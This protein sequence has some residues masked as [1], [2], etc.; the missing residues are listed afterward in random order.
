MSKASACFIGGD[1]G[2]SRLRLFL[3]DAAGERLATVDGPGAA[4]ARHDYEALFDRLVSPWTEQHG[5]LPAILCGM[6]GSS[7]GWEQVPYQRCPARPEDIADACLA[8]RGGRIRL[9]PGLSCRNRI[10]AP[11]VMR[12]EETQI[13]GALELKPELRRGQ[14]LLC[15]PGT[16]TKWAISDAGIVREFLTALTGEFFS[17]LSKHSL[18]SHDIAAH[19]AADDLSAFDQALT[20]GRRSS[21]ADVLHRLFECRS[22]RLGGELAPDSVAAYLSG[23]LIESDVSGALRLLAADVSTPTVQ[24]IGSP[25]L[26]A[27][28]ARALAAHGH[29][30]AVLDG[31][32]A[33]L[34]GLRCIHRLSSGV[35][36]HRG[37]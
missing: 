33:S 24:V 15:L 19:P 2:T 4:A 25:E 28:Y 37:N 21:D 36:A 9:V 35:H 14:H 12:G 32:A 18:L 31:D 8:L 1:W 27:L 20:D 30:L 11:D 16:H 34:A 5:L 10:D 29:A 23:T 3:C 22:R 26:T 6:V 13:L 7:I 17:V